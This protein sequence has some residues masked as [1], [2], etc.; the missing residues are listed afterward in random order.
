[1]TVTGVKILQS[2]FYRRKCQ[3]RHVVNLFP[4]NTFANNSFKCLFS[5]FDHLVKESCATCRITKLRE[6]DVHEACSKDLQALSQ[7]QIVFHEHKIFPTI[8]PQN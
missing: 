1:M 8:I 3:L 2:L 5:K 4:Q 7:I 6:G